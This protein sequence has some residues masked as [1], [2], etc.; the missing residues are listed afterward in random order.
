MISWKQN[1]RRRILVEPQFQMRVALW[2]SMLAVIEV[3]IG[4]VA[5]MAVALT[6]IWVPAGDHATLFYKFV[7]VIAVFILLIIVFNIFIAIY[8]SH[9]VAGPLYRLKQSMQQVGA[10]DLSILIKFRATDE[11]QDLK[12]EFNEMVNNLRERVKIQLRKEIK[13]AKAPAVGKQTQARKSLAAK[14]PA[15][16]SL[17]KLD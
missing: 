8:L 9:R 14:K 4:S 7:M 17:F 3:L 10:G 11:L 12:D 2:G 1:K 15:S 6:S 16:S 13:P 5:V